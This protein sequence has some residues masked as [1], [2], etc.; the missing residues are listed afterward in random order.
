[1][2]AEPPVGTSP[3][4]VSTIRARPLVGDAGQR[5]TEVL[6]ADS[7]LIDL[8][9]RSAQLM[10]LD[11]LRCDPLLRNPLPVPAVV[12]LLIDVAQSS[13]R[14]EL[15]GCQRRLFIGAEPL[16]QRLVRLPVVA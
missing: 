11:W 2:T 13:Q 9:N 8:T 6:R 15:L 14:V 10:E 1:M 5:G 12:I 4:E 16:C 3:G 7:S